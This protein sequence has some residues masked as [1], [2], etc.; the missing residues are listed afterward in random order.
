MTSGPCLPMA[1][2]RADAVANAPRRSSARPT[3][4][5]RRRHDPEAVRRVE[6]PERDPRVG[7]RRERG[8]ARW[9]SSFPRGSSGG[10]LGLMSPERRDL[11]QVVVPATLSGYAAS[12]Y[13]GPPA[14]SRPDRWAARS[15]RSGVRRTGRSASAGPVIGHRPAAGHRRRRVPLAG[16]RPRGRARASAAAASP[17][18]WTTWTSRWTR[19]CSPPIPTPPTIR[20]SIRC[21]ERATS[22]DVTEVVREE[23][24]LAAQTDLLLCRDDCAGLCPTC[25]AD[26]NAGPCACR[27]RPRRTCLRTP[28]QSRSVGPR[29]PGS[30]CGVAI[31]RR[32]A[33]PP[34]PVRAA[35]RPSCPTAC[36]IPAD[37]IAAR[38]RSRSRTPERD[39]RRRGRD[40]GRQGAAG[41]G[42]R[43]ARRRSRACLTYFVV[44]LV[45]RSEVIEAELARHAGVDRAR[46]EIHE[47]PDVIGMGEKPLRRRPEEAQFEPRGRPHDAEAGPIRRVSVRRQ[48]RRHARRID[49]AARPPRRGRAGHGRHAVSH[50][51]RARAGARRRRQRRLLRRRSWWG[52][53]TSARSTRATSSAGPIRSSA[54]ST[55]ARRRRRARRSCARRTSC[56]SGRPVCNYVG[57]IEGR[58]I[59]PGLQRRT[60]RGRRRLRRLRRQRRAQVLRV[61]WPPLRRAPAGACARRLRAAAQSASS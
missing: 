55:S 34:R 28:W 47:A 46:I 32:R 22:V 24:A 40:G 12:G 56:S 51:P 26:L 5:R 48:H 39:S 52:S 53:P 11:T 44:Q 43:G 18:C 49:R 10:A 9:R 37:T 1:L 29:S 35:A 23:L 6:G 25:G 54:C 31:T 7:Q 50:R 8:A 42:R 17:R 36:A 60:P 16:A 57:N 41:G 58:D 59:L 2:E 4:P 21:S 45:G 30:V 61:R 13:S 20:I 15:R 38:S 3:R 19:R 27:T 14:G 33:W